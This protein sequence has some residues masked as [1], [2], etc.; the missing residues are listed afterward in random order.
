MSEPALELVGIG[1]RFG[2]VEALRGVDFV[3]RPG[4]VHALLG[5]NGAGKSTLLHIAFGLIR[6]DRGV[7]RVRGREVA[8]HSP[9]EARALG[10]GMVHQHFTSIGALTVAE[11][12]RLAVG[13]R[14]TASGPGTRLLEGLDPL[15][16][17]EDL[18]V[19]LRQRLEIVN[20][21][22]TGARILLLDEP[23]A[24]L[25]PGE[26]DELLGLARGF[27]REGGAVTLVTHKL[28]EALGAADRVTVLRG[29]VV[30]LAAGIAGQTETSLAAAM[31]GQAGGREDGRT[32]TRA[33][34]PSRPRARLGPITIRAGEVV[35]IAAVEGNGQR[36]M[37]RALAGLPVASPIS[38]S[39][40][41]RVAFVPEDRTVEGLIPSFS[42]TEN[43]VLGLTDDPRWARGHRLDWAAARA[44]AEELIRSFDIRTAG[45]DAPVST[46][47]GGNQQKLVLARALARR[48]DLVV[49]EN[50]TRGLDIRA[51][52]EVHERLRQAARDGAAVLL[53]STDLDEVLELGERVL[54]MHRGR[55]GEAPAGADRRLVGAMMLGVDV[56]S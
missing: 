55:I 51:T 8:L 34:I 44:Q 40:E 23:S 16:R 50:P 11:N 28:R 36:E 4:E 1:K 12:L 22:A 38:V 18:G 13:S 47:S 31:I 43:L 39:A 32:G 53:Y 5:E 42:V 37:L 27:A 26:T 49:A 2:S 45:P 54:V 21:L 41:G 9:R 20:A 3:L 6:V 48:P 35:G 29:G 46:L 19:A 17:V 24:V 7:I 25:T 30:T 52:G 56:G 33:P 14:W 10:I 15:T